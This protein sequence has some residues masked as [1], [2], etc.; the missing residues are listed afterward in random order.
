MRSKIVWTSHIVVTDAQQVLR[1][2]S[3]W[4]YMIFTMTRDLIWILFK[5]KHWHLSRLVLVRLEV[6]SRLKA[7]FINFILS[8]NGIKYCEQYKW[9]FFFTSSVSSAKGYLLQQIMWHTASLI[10]KDQILIL[11]LQEKFFLPCL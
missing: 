4:N 3:P 2:R 7:I 6:L 9:F 1:H 5:I 10:K 8:C 11:R